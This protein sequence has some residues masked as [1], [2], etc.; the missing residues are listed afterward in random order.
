MNSY[1]GDSDSLITHQTV[2][3]V[4]VD[5][6]IFIHLCTV[7]VNQRQTFTRD[8]SHQQNVCM[9]CCLWGLVLQTFLDATVNLTFVI[10]KHLISIQICCK[11]KT[12]DKSTSILCIHIQEYHHIIIQ[13]YIQMI[14][15]RH[16]TR[17][18]GKIYADLCKKINQEHVRCRC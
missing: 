5:V 15:G 8:S 4:C 9:E 2:Q 17:M 12:H 7:S 3:N 10:L 11:C 1:R 18:D 16:S 13:I 14:R 6:V